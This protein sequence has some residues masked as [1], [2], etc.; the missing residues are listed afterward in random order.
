MPIA[1]PRLGNHVAPAQTY[2]YI[3]NQYPNLGA[4]HNY[5][6]KVDHQIIS[7]RQ[8]ESLTFLEEEGT[9]PSYE[10]NENDGYYTAAEENKK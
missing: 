10:R 3:K 2:N 7:R 6:E 1:S 4:L 5:K 8:V 9:H